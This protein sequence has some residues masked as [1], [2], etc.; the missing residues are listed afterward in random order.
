MA[1]PRSRSL[2]YVLA[3]IGFLA[4]AL[5]LSLRK[6]R[7]GIA[8]TPATPA[9]RSHHPQSASSQAER[10]DFQLGTDGQ[11]QQR[12]AGGVVHRYGFVLKS[13]QLLHALVDQD[14][15][16]DDAIDVALELYGPDGGKLY[17]IDSPTLA[18]GSEEIF[19]VANAPG[20]YQ[21][22][23]D[24]LRSEGTYRIR[25]LP[26]HQASDS[27]RLNARA[28]MLFYQ[29][30]GFAALRP[31]KGPAALGGF[32]ESERLW[33][34]LGMPKRRAE[35]FRRAGELFSRQWDYRRALVFRQRAVD[36]YR[37]TGNHYLE[38]AQQV[39]M[40]I[41][42]KQLGDLERAED[43][44]RRAISIAHRNG[45]SEI[46]ANALL[47]LG[48]LLHEQGD[49]WGALE[50]CEAALVLIRRDKREELQD[51]GPL[52]L[53]GQINV[54]LGKFQTALAHYDEALRVL[55]SRRSATWRAAIL[56]RIS[57]LYL[58]L[59][60]LSRALAYARLA[61]GYR[62]EAGD[63]RGKAVTL[64]GMS[65]ILQQKQ[66]PSQARALQ[67]QA[68]AIFYQIGDPSS[69]ATAHLNLGRLW[70]AEKNTRIALAH[71]DRALDLFRQ[72]RQPE[73][74]MAALY[75][76][77]QAE[78]L[79]GN[80]IMARR[81]IEGALAIL[82]SLSGAP[83]DELKS[84]YLG[85]R[86]KGYGLSIDL[87]VKTLPSSTSSADVAASFEMSEKARWQQL[88]NSLTPAQFRA[89]ILKRADPALLRE[90]RKLESEINR[91][92]S[93]RL[94][95]ER[96]G[97][98]IISAQRTQRG[99]MEKLQSLDVRL[100]REDAWAASWGRS[101]PISLREA[102]QLL[103]PDSILLEYHLGEARSFV[104]LVTPS[105]ADVFALPAR[106][107]IEHQARGLHDLLS[108][109]Q[110]SVNAE[111]AILLARELSA[112]LLKPVAGRLGSHGLIVVPDGA[113]HLV[114][115]AL[116]PDPE[117]EVVKGGHWPTPLIWSHRIS[118][119][120]SV[121][122]LRSIRGELA[123]R[124]TAPGRL[125]VLADPAFND[126][127]FP[128]LPF[129][130]REAEAILSLVPRGQ[131][132]LKAFGDQAT[133]EL[134]LSGKLVGYQI[135]HFAT[136]AINHPEYPQLS[137]IVLSNTAPS[138]AQEAHLRLK[139]IQNLELPA[140]L[141]VLS[142]CRTALGRYVSGEGYMSLTQGFMYAGAARV[143]VSL[144]NVNE[145][146]T[147]KF[148]DR[149]Y[150]A[151]FYEGKSPA[152]ALRVAQRWMAQE[153]PW[154]SPYYWAGFELQGEWR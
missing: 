41:A 66:D 62:E 51:L 27:E 55:G 140:D 135:V 58:K 89:G 46:E 68:L 72:E 94:R 23:I 100:R 20:T 25:V 45:Y 138:R 116:L 57:E 61:L 134:V 119:L 2:V 141:I 129:S 1:S 154:R 47:N 136:H 113:V 124:H 96:D 12:L 14:V 125:A 146:S 97:L 77:A 7:V 9:V 6:A 37:A 92:E 15:V 115:F 150:R 143:L 8:M 120:P 13:G 81:R 118:Y 54:S 99:E 121:S 59:G 114:P 3:L 33:R 112:I 64:A 22:E 111:K 65:L 29:A 91:T 43:R 84:A 70:L 21:V 90:R 145:E 148:M 16:K 152:E 75:E 35:S 34:K 106:S 144:W 102:Q 5:A 31:P 63:E 149:F 105:T 17:K 11:S 83:S 67:E 73:G 133:R 60:D 44:Y 104:W 40:G 110:W 88:A 30:A 42:H 56:S 52:S 80:P 78:R 71:L 32:L 48:I 127:E 28:E 109:S 69:E 49:S 24:G 107:V 50:A 130:R 36:L 18:L 38:A 123:D 4:L 76:S 117:R 86:E 87:I 132:T 95:L 108:E 122:V 153:T 101:V 126:P 139:D 142:A 128:Q 147:P 10:I 39:S 93:Q 82:G 85:A 103:D 53:M 26:I 98:P 19:L 151:L 131:R 137:S 79:R 74:E